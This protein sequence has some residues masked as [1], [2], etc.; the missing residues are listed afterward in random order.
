[1]PLCPPPTIIVSAAVTNATE[2]ESIKPIVD[3]TQKA[4]S[5]PAPPPTTPSQPQPPP[6]LQ[7][8]SQQKPAPVQAQHPLRD[9]PVSQQQQQQRKKEPLHA[10]LQLYQQQQQQLQQQIQQLTLQN[11]Q[12]QQQ[13]LDGGN[14]ANCRKVRRQ[15][16][17]RVG[18]LGAGAFGVVTLEQDLWTQ[19]TYALKAVSKGYLAKLHM[20]ES[21]LNE[22]RILGMVDSA[23]IIRLYATY[24]GS[25]HVYFLLEAALGGELFTVYERWRL[26]GS[27]KHAKFYV[28]CTVEALAHL[29]EKRVTYRDLKPENL[30]LDDRGYCKLTDMGLAKVTNGLTFTLVGT[31]DYMA[32]E[33]INQTGHG[34]PVDWWMLG[35]LLFELLVGRAP[36]EAESDNERYESVKRGIE[37]VAFPQSCRGE[38]ADLVR[39]LCRQAPEARPRAP[40][41]RDHAWYRDFSWQSLRALTMDAPYKPKVRHCCDLGNFRRCEE[42]PTCL[43]YEDRGKFANFEDSCI[44]PT[45][46]TSTTT[47]RTPGTASTP[48]PPP[49]QP[50]RMQRGGPAP[51]ASSASLNGAL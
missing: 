30:L 12:N 5:L 13:A 37:A 29:H 19:K 36:F 46:A 9:M 24:N 17:Q 40:A 41:V 51:S 2:E 21:V 26:Y 23:F 18:R 8:R 3:K 25:E 15:D 32:P 22:K 16:L 31:P 38:A 34:R 45:T 35:V 14:R 42:D 48:T 39:R 4:G 33:V 44:H 28:A 43:P 10:Q 1:M 6:V 11:Q 27:E 50:H 7:N 47:T 20:E 49:P